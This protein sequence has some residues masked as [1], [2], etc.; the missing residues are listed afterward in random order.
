MTETKAINKIDVYKKPV[1]D[2]LSERYIVDYFQRDYKWQ[3]KHVTELINDLEN[4]FLQDYKDGD[5]V[6]EVAKFGYY[7]LGSIIL[8][9][10][11]TEYSI[12]DGQQRLTTLTLLLI[13]LHNL[14]VKLKLERPINLL[15]LISNDDYEFSPNIGVKEWAECLESLYKGKEEFNLSDKSISIQNLIGRYGDIGNLLSEK[16]QNGALQQ[17]IVWLKQ[18]VI[19]SQIITYTDEDAYKIFEAMNDRGLDLTYT[20]MLKGYLLVKV[21]DEAKISELNILWKNITHKIN[22]SRENED[23]R[24]FTAFFRAKYA[25]TSGQ[26]LKD[27]GDGDFERIGSNFYRW[28]IQNEKLMGIDTR[29]QLIKFL[30][31]DIPFFVDCYIQIYEASQKLDEKLSPIYYLNKLGFAETISYSLLLSP[32]KFEDEEPTIQKK[33]FLVSSFLEMFTVFMAVNGKRYA[34]SLIK[35]FLYPLAIRIRDTSVKELKEILL[36]EYNNFDYFLDGINVKKY[37]NDYNPEGISSLELNGQ[38]RNFIK[39]ILARITTFIEQESGI[40]STFEKY[41]NTTQKKPFQIEHLWCDDYDSFKDEFD[42]RDEWLGHRNSIGALIL[43]PEG[44]NQS[45]NK[46]PYL[47]KLPHYL[48]E[49]LLAQSLHPECYKKNPNFTNFVKKNNLPFKPHEQM[50]IADI[51]DRIDLYFE[52]VKLIWNE[53]I[54][55]SKEE[56]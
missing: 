13:F 4:K 47:K 34:Q 31:D 22:L 20:E 14:Q 18:N 7:Y 21:Q 24:F 16:I 6:K 12:I 9:A 30:E 29:Q 48:K 51:D 42:Q 44:T 32:I 39:F 25:K 11:G 46:D 55:Q 52:I 33:L 54:F 56:Q 5:D 26:K 23:L 43:L 45:H 37:P 28:L 50:K 10:K 53:S 36:L 40:E 38:N 27:M 15:N 2:I 3:T 41:V 35:N 1:K 17:F 8:S 49:N 19:F